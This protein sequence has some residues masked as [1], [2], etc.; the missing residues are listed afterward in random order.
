MFEK[1]KFDIDFTFFMPT[2]ELRL[3]ILTVK[4]GCQCDIGQIPIK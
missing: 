2:C 1:V 3:A 4:A